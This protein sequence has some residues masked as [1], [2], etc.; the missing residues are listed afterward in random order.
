MAPSF[1]HT[2]MRQAEKGGPEP[3]P[4][5]FSRRFFRPNSHAV[6]D[7]KGR[8]IYIAITPGQRHETHKGRRASRQR[9]RQGVHRRRRLDSNR[10]RQAIRDKKNRAVTSRPGR[11]RK[12]PKPR[13]LYSKAIRRMPLPRSEAFPRH[14][15]ALRKDGAELSRTHPTRLRL[16]MACVKLGH[17]P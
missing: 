11:P 4:R 13:A 10:F 9:S 7:T 3:C 14:R 17:P 8:P 15:H 12:L 16:A 2:K 1:A 5:P 6:A